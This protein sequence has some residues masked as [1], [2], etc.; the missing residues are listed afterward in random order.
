L[1]NQNCAEV[2]GVLA[3]VSG[4]NRKNLGRYSG[5]RDGGAARF[6][7]SD[8]RGEIGDRRFTAIGFLITPESQP[9]SGSGM[10]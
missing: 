4:A 1:R 9:A 8:E 5:L 10:A 2:E 6:R 3:D 7:V